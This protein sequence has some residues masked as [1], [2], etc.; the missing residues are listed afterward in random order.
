VVS[1]VICSVSTRR[2]ISDG[3]LCTNGLDVVQPSTPRLVLRQWTEAATAVLATAFGQLRLDELVS[4][5]TT[6]NLPSQRVMQRIGMTRDPGEDFNHPRVDKG[7]WRRHVLYR[8]SRSDWE[9][10]QAIT[11]SGH[12]P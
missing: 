1:S 4:F 12:R 10:R 11:A 2:L 7:P 6:D 5:T 9:P 8:L 3:T